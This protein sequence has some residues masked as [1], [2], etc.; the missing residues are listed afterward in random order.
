MKRILFC[1]RTTKGTST[2]QYM[3]AFIQYFKF[4]ERDIR[5]NFLDT[6]YM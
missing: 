3:S 4:T 5:V 2:P 6:I 1:Y